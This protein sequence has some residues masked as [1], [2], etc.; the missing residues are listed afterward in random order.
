MRINN[1]ISNAHFARLRS[2]MKSG[3]KKPLHRC[4]PRQMAI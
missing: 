3:N 4:N 1:D 2:K